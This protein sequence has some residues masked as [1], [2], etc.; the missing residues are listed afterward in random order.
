MPTPSFHDWPGNHAQEALAADNLATLI[1]SAG[2]AGVSRDGLVRAPHVPE[3][4]LGVLSRAMVTAGQVRVVKV[5]G[6]MVYRATG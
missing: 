6:E 1:A 2:A 4:S 3:E 5:G